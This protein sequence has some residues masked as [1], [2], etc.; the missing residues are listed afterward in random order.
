MAQSTLRA[1]EDVQ[2]FVLLS[3]HRIPAVG[4]GTWKSGTQASDSVATAILEAGYRHVDT[5]WEYGVHEEVGLGL[6]AAMDAGIER[7]D[8]FVTSKLWCHDLSPERVRPALLNTLE[9]LQLDYLDLYLIHWPFR[10]KE[11]AS[12]PPKAGDVLNFDMEG[13]WREMEKLVAQ[14]LVRDIGISNF[15][16]KKLNKLT[17]FAQTMPS[18]C[19]MEMHPG[20]RND[21]MLEACKKNGIHVTAYSPLGSQDNGRDLIHDPT[22]EKVAKK[23]NKSPGQVLVRWAIQRGTSVIP[24]STNPERIKENMQV[25]DWAI[26]EQDFNVLSSISDQKRVLH[27]EDLFVNKNDGPFPSVAD[28]WD[29]E[30]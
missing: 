2:S 8:L 5:A 25:F 29:H 15:T 10:L 1:K 13:V 11:G 7:K 3:G 22:V 20:W 16:L 24:K 9:E 18:V 28:I 26:P 14:N 6:K 21:K 4:L 23:L 17:T 27:G 12:R 30:D 19:Q